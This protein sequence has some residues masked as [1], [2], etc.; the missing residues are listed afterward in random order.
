MSLIL[1][2]RDVAVQVVRVVRVG[3]RC[4]TYINAACQTLLVCAT[5]TY[6]CF[7]AL[8]TSRRPGLSICT[9]WPIVLARWM[10]E[11]LCLMMAIHI[12]CQ[13]AR[14]ECTRQRLRSQR[15]L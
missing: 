15:K 6:E 12:I 3:S 10:N 1:A 14:I 4:C 9:A 5:P 2:P 8:I 11:R 13:G 7:V